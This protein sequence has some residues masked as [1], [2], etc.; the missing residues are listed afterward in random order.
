MQLSG[1]WEHT[2]DKMTPTGW[3]LGRVYKLDPINMKFG[4]DDIE[5]L[6]KDGGMLT[7]QVGA[8]TFQYLNAQDKLMHYDPQNA[9]EFVYS[10]RKEWTCENGRDKKQGKSTCAEYMA[11]P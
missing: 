6:P 9:E 3:K 8:L 5:M 11:L 10:T 7:F 1:E 4:D 2:E